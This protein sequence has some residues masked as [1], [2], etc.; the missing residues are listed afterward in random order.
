MTEHATWV[1]TYRMKAPDRRVTAIAIRADLAE[2]SAIGLPI[3][4]W[5]RNTPNRADT[6]RVK[7]ETEGYESVISF[8]VYGLGALAVLTLISPLIVL[9]APLIALLGPPGAAW[10]LGRN[11]VPRVG[12]IMLWWLILASVLVFL[13]PLIPGVWY[14][15]SSE[16]GSPPESFWLVVTA[17]TIAPLPLS[18][19]MYQHR[20]RSR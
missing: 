6:E 16:S 10:W 5:L 13:A 7:I 19:V 8:Y 3:Y 12:S 15:A 1:D 14:I 11:Y 4:E 20:V 9:S 2:R 18:T 17:L